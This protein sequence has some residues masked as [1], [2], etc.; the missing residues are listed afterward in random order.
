MSYIY[1]KPNGHIR[2]PETGKPLPANLI[3]RLPRSRFW[4]RRLARHEITEHTEKEYRNQ[5][6]PT[7][8][9][10]TETQIKKTA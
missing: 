1:A 4:L 2:N 5:F 6:R 9:K 10:S 7:E 8:K 3:T